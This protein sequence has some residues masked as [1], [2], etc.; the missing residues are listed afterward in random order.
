M[1]EPE[2]RISDTPTQIELAMKLKPEVPMM[3]TTLEPVVLEKK[4]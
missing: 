2:L 4:T 3:S 1:E